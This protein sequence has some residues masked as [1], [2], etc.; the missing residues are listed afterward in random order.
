MKL[1]KKKICETHQDD[2]DTS[3]EGMKGYINICLICKDKTTCKHFPKLGNYGSG[4][5]EWPP[6]EIIIQNVAEIQSLKQIEPLKIIQNDNC[7]IAG[8]QIIENVR[9]KTLSQYEGERPAKKS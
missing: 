4:T 2:I 9:D 3:P 1:F 5:E 7:R 8:K 6:I